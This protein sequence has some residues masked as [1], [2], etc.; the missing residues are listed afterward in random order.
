M[1]PASS[2]HACL[3]SVAVHM[4][5]QSL[6]CRRPA[7]LLLNSTH[8]KLTAERMLCDWVCSLVASPAATTSSPELSR[9]GKAACRQHRTAW[10]LAQQ[11]VL[12]LIPLHLTV[13][14]RAVARMYAESTKAA[15]GQECML[16][17]LQTSYMCMMPDAPISAT[18]TCTAQPSL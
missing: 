4:I 7:A 13:F 10:Q 1:R 11:Q 17:W 14:C 6:P 9:S 18:L 8:K 16:Q 3:V 2:K 5:S 12:F 15:A